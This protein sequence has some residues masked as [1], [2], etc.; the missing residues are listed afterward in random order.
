MEITEMQRQMFNSQGK[1]VTI[2]LKNGKEIQGICDFYTQP[3]D[4]EPEV[5][6][7]CIKQSGYSSL[8]EITEP[9]IEEIR[10]H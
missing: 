4:N 3:L 8:T 6:A 1:H 9:E 7:I 2:K 10:K 5:A